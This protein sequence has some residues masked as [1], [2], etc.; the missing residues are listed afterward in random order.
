MYNRS[1]SPS[2]ALKKTMNEATLYRLLGRIS[3]ASNI[4]LSMVA[5]WGP[6]LDLVRLFELLNSALA[7]S[8]RRSLVGLGTKLDI[9]VYIIVF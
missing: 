6:E 1:T 2:W 8:M 3:N 9:P 7:V 5:G 4:E